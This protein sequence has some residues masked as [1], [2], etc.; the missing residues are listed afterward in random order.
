MTDEQFEKLIDSKQGKTTPTPIGE[1]AMQIVS[2]LAAQRTADKQAARIVARVL[3]AGLHPKRVH[4][5]GDRVF[6]EAKTWTDRARLVTHLPALYRAV[7]IGKIGA[8][9]VSIVFD[10]REQ[11]NAN[12]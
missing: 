9:S 8:G 10:E 2:R 3:P 5:V 7:Q 4:V 11:G 6:V 12:V 1:M